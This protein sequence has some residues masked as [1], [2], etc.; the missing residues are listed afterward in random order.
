M[1]QCHFAAKI[2]FP[3]IPG[4]SRLENIYIYIYIYI[5]NTIIIIFIIITIIIHP[6]HYTKIIQ[7]YTN[8]VQS[9]VSMELR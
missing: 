4:T 5:Y 8:N 7:L 1:A 2:D 6:K 3:D 9:T